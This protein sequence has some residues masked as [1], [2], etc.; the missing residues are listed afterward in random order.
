[1]TRLTLLQFTFA[2]PAPLWCH[3]RSGSTP[4]L[5]LCPH[6]LKGPSLRCREIAVAGPTAGE[7]KRAEA[8]AVHA[9]IGEGPHGEAAEELI[10]PRPHR[11][12]GPHPE[13]VAIGW[14][15]Q[16]PLE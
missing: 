15:R 1:M 5:P 13:A 6:V 14:R 8:A 11:E 2:L 16:V 7:R 3:R 9:A 4:L 10:E 12:E